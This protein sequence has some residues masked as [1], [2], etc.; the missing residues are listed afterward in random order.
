M[1]KTI[2][3]NSKSRSFQFDAYSELIHSKLMFTKVMSQQDKKTGV[4]FPI[5]FEKDR[6][7]FINSIFIKDKHRFIKLEMRDVNG[8]KYFIID[9]KKRFD[10]KWLYPKHMNK[11]SSKVAT[12]KASPINIEI[13]I[14]N[15][16]LKKGK[17]N[18]SLVSKTNN[19]KMRQKLKD[20]LAI[21]WYMMSKEERIRLSG[22][23]NQKKK[24]VAPKKGNTGFKS[25]DAMNYRVSG[26]FGTGKRR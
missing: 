1:K 2:K 4:L 11:L 21:K 25:E 16:K 22:D 12:K 3:M 6:I 20:P 8:D 17:E 18:D 14:A 19:K 26:S 9:D 13:K 5:P 24:K 23:S 10:L 7:D 15:K